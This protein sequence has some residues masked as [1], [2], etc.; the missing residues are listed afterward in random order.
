MHRAVPLLVAALILLEGACGRN[1]RYYL[2]K[3]D[4]LY[5]KGAYS[6]AS[7]NYRKAIQK[8]P[9]FGPAYYQLG[10]SELRLGKS[11]DA[12]Q[13]LS[14]AVELLPN[15]EDVKVTLAGL[16][17]AAYVADRRRPEIFRKKVDTL[18]DQLL[19]KN[20]KS[21]DGLRL[22]GH[23][24][25]AG[26]N[27]AE[28]E[29]LYRRANEAKPMQPEV[30]MAWAQVMLQDGKVHEG[31]DLAFQFIEKNKTYLPIYDLLFRYYVQSNRLADAEKILKTRSANNPNDP[32]GVLE[33]AAFY[34]THSR[35]SDMKAALQRLLDD[36][37]TFPQAHLQA[38]D[39]YLRL[40]R[41]DE[42][43]EQ[44]N[45]GAKANPKDKVVYL[46][47]T[48]DV[49][50]AQGKGEQAEQVVDEILA[51]QPGD[52]AAK[53]VRASLLL[54]KGGAENLAKAV[55]LF[56]GLVDKNP[57]NAVWHFN[58]GR[59]LLAKGDA[60]LAKTQLQEA[61][62][63][64]H[65]F[66][67]PRVLLA[68]MSQSKRDYRSSLQYTT[69]I[70]T[71]NPRL[72]RMRLLHA[73]SLMNTGDPA[74]GRT[75]MRELEKQFPQDP[76]IQLEMGAMDLFDNR[77]PAAEERFRKLLAD[78]KGDLRAT[79]GLVRTLTAENHPDAALSFLQEEVKKSPKSGALRSLLASTEMQTGKYD[80]AVIEYQH[81]AADN[82]NSPQVYLA[83]GNAYRQR[84]DLAN[85]IASFQ[86]AEALAPNDIAPLALLAES[87]TLSGQ[88]PQALEMYRRALQL[89]PDNAVLMNATAYLIAETGGSLDEALK[90]AQK[91][92]AAD[93]HQANFSD[94]L[95]WIYFKKDQN[96]N[97]LEVFQAL[98][99]K[100]PES[101]TFHYH[102]GMA[103]LKRGD[104]KTAEA[105]L[106]DALS[107]KP[108]SQVR[109]DIETALG[110][111]G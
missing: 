73:I 62:K 36:P 106:K 46:K 91:A 3:G 45:A 68:E 6:D 15:R 22:K 51:Q 61:V 44:Y 103:L 20:A 67:P 87:F 26:Q 99:K 37:K 28:A 72:T 95:G 30:I 47:R 29:D 48:A 102:F 90:L 85:T 64:R 40:Q 60:E 24:A 16:A 11:S 97:A 71:L 66:V 54:K 13:A 14:R 82:P 52:E 109:H 65:D 1:P 63:R 2:D 69:E 78:G 89:K 42:A 75:E 18:A 56:Q 76:D 55:T 32:G 23:L 21:Y 94:T 83:L 19:A 53:G 110:K 38:G 79:T 12:Y 35:E 108:S 70:L 31:E 17:M 100:N 77:L 57:D 10:L 80:L 96:D 4:K 41:W 33:L 107:K 25:A 58:L 84:G 105:E 59:A 9:S 111:I 5:A 27:F 49:W 93:S 88:K 101:A 39:L 34:A 86:K 104:R 74:G 7:L 98:T 8:D 81:L 92:V 43:L 50:L